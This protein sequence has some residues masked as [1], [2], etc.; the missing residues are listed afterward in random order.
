MNRPTSPRRWL[1]FRLRSLL[2]LALVV[3]VGLGGWQYWRQ[4]GHKW[5]LQWAIAECPFQTTEEN[6]L[7]QE[8]AWD[9]EAWDS[10]LIDKLGGNV[11]ALKSPRDYQAW[12]TLF[13]SPLLWSGTFHDKSGR[14][15]RLYLLREFSLLSEGDPLSCVVTDE[16]RRLETWKSVAD[17]SKK[18]LTA[19]VADITQDEPAVLRIKCR[20]GFINPDYYYYELTP[21]SIDLV[22]APSAPRFPLEAPRIL[23]LR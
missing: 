13:R 5:R 8:L 1:Q 17:P 2:L 4:T 19:D 11:S 3:A 7:W 18:F 9:Q 14:S 21:L 12:A 10:G 23:I 16:L 22:D 20:F 6:L 15:H